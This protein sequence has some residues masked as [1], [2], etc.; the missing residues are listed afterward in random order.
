MIPSQTTYG[1]RKETPD[2]RQKHKRYGGHFTDFHTG[3]RVG[4]VIVRMA[5]IVNH[6]ET[7]FDEYE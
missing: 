2:E 7:A 3:G 4:R 1:H 6:G 5:E